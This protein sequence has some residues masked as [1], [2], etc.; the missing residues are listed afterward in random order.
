MF[1]CCAD[2]V[3]ADS[4]EVI[5][6]EPDALGAFGTR[7]GFSRLDKPSREFE[8]Q[9]EWESTFSPQKCVVAQPALGDDGDLMSIFSDGSKNSIFLF[10][11]SMFNLNGLD[12]LPEGAEDED[13]TRSTTPS[14]GSDRARKDD[15]GCGVYNWLFCE[16][17]GVTDADETDFEE[18]TEGEEL[19]IAD[20]DD[21]RSEARCGCCR[22]INDS[23]RIPT[24][25][26]PGKG[27]RHELSDA[28]E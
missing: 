6:E 19:E 9:P 14:G 10:D 18:E 5:P 20:E 28:E 8:P 27:M 11:P 26:A 25:C 3:E 21:N 2:D 1:F 22:R 7:K 23:S 16:G 13:P 17:D 12:S 15:K 24:F 4:V